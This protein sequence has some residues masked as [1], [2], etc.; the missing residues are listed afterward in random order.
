MEK[1]TDKSK[2]FEEY[3]ESI[4][5]L[6]NGY[7][8]DR[9]PI[10]SRYFF[11]ISD[12]WLSIVQELIEGL[13]ELGWNKQILQVKE[14]YGSLRFYCSGLPDEGWALEKLAC[15]K[16]EKTCEHCGE[17]GTLRTEGWYTVQCDKCYK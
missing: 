1:M 14:K 12:H 10:K 8:E 4:G 5:G 17:P 15:K 16:A 6:V 3:L 2:Q 7:F 13:I 11:S 9:D